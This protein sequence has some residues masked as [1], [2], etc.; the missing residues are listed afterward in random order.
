MLR[1]RGPWQKIA[2]DTDA[3]DD[4]TIVRAA[5]TVFLVL[6]LLASPI[7]APAQPA[8]KV[9]RIGVLVTGPPPREHICVQ[10]LRRGFADLGYVE[11][12]SHVLEIRWGKGP[13]E[14]TLPRFGAELVGLGVDVIVSVTSQGLVEAKPAMTS[15]PVVMAASN[16]PV[17][18]GLIAS[19]SRPGGNITGV[20]TFTGEMIAK[21]VQLLGEALPGV[22]RVAVFRLP[23]DQN[24]FIVRDLE[25]AAQQLGLKLQVI[26]VQR[27]D[28]FVGAFSAAVRGGARAVM[29]AQG[30]FFLQHIREIA[31]LALKHKLPSF[32]GEPTAADAGILM[33]AGASIPASC[34]RG[35]TFVDR[36]LKGARPADIPVEQ[37]TKFDLEINLKTA[38]ALG[39][40]IP[41][42]LVLRA[43]RVIQ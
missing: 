33:T 14:E 24:D 9:A 5:L 3:T 10:A 39:L 12:R 32:S 6:S 26:E 36:I 2:G 34:H 42:S 38:S 22:S 27:P 37:P 28:D 15:V 18:R 43:D 31:G 19:L 40:S 30:P 21:R 20:A 1:T 4:M 35:A 8:G 25:R 23:G 41:P 11:G 16:Y 29:T 17:E 7:P 13:P